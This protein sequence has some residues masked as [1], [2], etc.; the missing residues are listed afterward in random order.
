MFLYI[1]VKVV[2]TAVKLVLYITVKVV[3][4]AVKLVLIYNFESGQNSSKACSDI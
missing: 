3:R 1:T 4:T 2:R